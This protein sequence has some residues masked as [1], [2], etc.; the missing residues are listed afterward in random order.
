MI[1]P[2]SGLIS[3][4]AA[5]ARRIPNDPGNSSQQAILANAPASVCGHSDNGRAGVL[6]SASRSG[7]VQVQDR[8][9]QR[10]QAGDRPR[11]PEAAMSPYSA[12]A[13]GR[14]L[15]I[16]WPVP[17]KHRTLSLHYFHRVYLIFSKDAVGT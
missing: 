13:T 10:A 11:D 17:L 6:G 12:P 7:G 3:R 14:P 4:I 1:S 15:V 8:I 2:V 5:R 16:I 9:V